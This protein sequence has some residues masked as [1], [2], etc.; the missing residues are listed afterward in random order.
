MKIVLIGAGNVGHH[1]GLAIH[2]S[3]AEVIQVIGRKAKKTSHL[4]KILNCSYSTN[5]DE[6]SQD[7]E[8]YLLAVPDDQILK[9]AESLPL[10][11]TASQI[12]A[13]TSG[14]T[15]LG[16]L[17]DLFSNFGVFYPLQTFTIGRKLEFS[18]IPVCLESNNEETLTKLT[19]LAE[20]VSQ[21]VY[22]LD[23]EKRAKIH[24]AAVFANNF[25]NHMLAKAEQYC[26]SE[27]LEFEILKPLI[28]ET[29][30]KAMTINPSIAQTGPARRNDSKTIWTHLD[31][32]KD[33]PQLSKLYWEVTRSIENFYD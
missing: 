12:I 6:I 10:G 9:V 28:K 13:H 18:Q 17:G 11:K 15:A 23:S 19:S 33:D 16:V 8:V 21:K 25:T 29:V 20:K 3:D 14:G 1:L 4:A 5:I 30:A 32:L 22:F 31:L 7:A 24:L 26:S 2:Q 27:N